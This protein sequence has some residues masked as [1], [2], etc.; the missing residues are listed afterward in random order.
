MKIPAILFCFSLLGFFAFPLTSA[1]QCSGGGIKPGWVDSPESVTDEYFFAAGV[2]DDT[3]AALADRI[4]SAKQ[5][6]LKNISEMIEVS[7]KNFLLLEQSSQEK[8]GKVITDSN[9][10]SIT[11]TSTNATLKNVGII[12]T[13]EDPKTCTIWLRAKVSKRQV[14]QGKREGMA[15]TLF[16]VL[17]DQLSVAQN[18]VAPLDNRLSAVDAAL[19]VL[20]RIA[21][22][23][24][25]EANTAVYYNQLLKRLQQNLEISRNDLEQAKK[26][27]TDADSLINQAA[28]QTDE[29]TKSKLLGSAASSYRT[30]LVKHSNGLPPLFGTSDILFKLGEVEAIRGNSCGAKGYYQQSA[31]SKQLNDRQL[32]AKKRGDALVCSAEDMER[33]LWRQY[34]EGRPTVIVCYYH[35]NTGQGVWHKACDGMNNILKPLGADTTIRVKSISADQLQ[36]LQNG[37]IPDNLAEKDKLLLGIFASGKINQRIDK[38]SPGK[39]HEYQFGGGMATFLVENGQ[40]TFSDRFQGTTG[41][42]P[43]SSQMVMDVLAI[44]I[45]KRW[46]DKF[47]KFLHHDLDQ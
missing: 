8:S 21:L 4:S 27:L 41:W 42:N 23:F 14:E 20:P 11:K 2:S 40:T 47:S 45:V 12:D 37:S 38:E 22:E 3:K 1:A 13:W 18:D 44:N 43:I 33:T 9:L 24:I 30:L 5:N 39:N 15:K 17:N 16:G 34:F 10:L 32:L 35:S 31:D 19:D 46:R 7:V 26:I 28:S 6:A 29:S 25:P 36:K